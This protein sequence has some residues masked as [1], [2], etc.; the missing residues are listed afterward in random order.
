[1]T[2][3]HFTERRVEAAD[4]SCNKNRAFDGSSIGHWSCVLSRRGMSI[5]GG[6]DIFS[7]MYISVPIVCIT[8]N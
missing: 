4:N 5:A 1:M 8:K 7:I 2:V 6:L 3:I